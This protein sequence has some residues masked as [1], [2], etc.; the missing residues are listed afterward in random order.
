M[1][2]EIPGVLESNTCL[3]PMITEKTYTLIRLHKHYKNQILF[4]DGGLMRQPNVYLDAI[5]TIEGYSASQ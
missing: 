4:E 3:L 1:Q 5:E 2:W